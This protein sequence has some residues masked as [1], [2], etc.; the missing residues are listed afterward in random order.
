MLHVT[1]LCINNYVSPSI[2]L[3]EQMLNRPEIEEEVSTCPM[4]N[5]WNCVSI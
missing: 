1:S 4:I 3:V 5:R 2:D